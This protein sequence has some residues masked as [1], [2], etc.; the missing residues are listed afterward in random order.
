[1]RRSLY[2]GTGLYFDDV[3][4][5]MSNHA[6]SCSCSVL[7]YLRVALYACEKAVNRVV[8]EHGCRFGS[9]YVTAGEDLRKQCE[10]SGANGLAI[11]ARVQ[12][13]RCF[14]AAKRG[15]SVVYSLAKLGQDRK[16][17]NLPGTFRTQP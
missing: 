1:M 12:I 5:A 4:E 7:I 11:R 2:S 13:L 15:G 10:I 16:A 8:R 6:H 9:H 14:L 3:E 17:E